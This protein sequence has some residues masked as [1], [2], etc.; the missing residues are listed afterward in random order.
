MSVPDE[1]LMAYA[2]GELSGAEHAAERAQV[3]AAMKADPEV[4]RKVERHRAMRLR[5][6]ATFDRVLDEPV[7]DRLI[8]AVRKTPAGKVTDINRMRAKRV[9]AAPPPASDVPTRSAR[10]LKW[11]HWGAAAASFVIGAIIAHFALTSS[12]ANDPIVSRGGHLV[13]QAGLAAALSNQL[14][15]QQATSA[16]VQIGTTFK[17]KAGEYC[18]T[19][20]LRENDP[21]G[22][23][24]CLSGSTWNINTLA[25]VSPS[26]GADGTY[27]QAG[28]AMPAAV[29]AAVEE[30]IVGDP[31]DSSGEAQARTSGWK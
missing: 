25:R 29:R 17:T 21:V 12:E 16:P 20:T 5:M 14:A 13:A 1:V 6:N 3:E 26:P 15:S 11:S 4:A 31:L 18:R 19:F 30:Q 22:G 10:S 24:A 9:A 2:D 28:T 23:L 8:A 7:P 27:R